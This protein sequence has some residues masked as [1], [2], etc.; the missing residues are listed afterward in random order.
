MYYLKNL[1]LH[2][3]QNSKMHNYIYLKLR[4]DPSAVIQITKILFNEVSVKNVTTLT[5]ATFSKVAHPHP[6]TISTISNLHIQQ[7]TYFTNNLLGLTL[8]IALL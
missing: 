8:L 3:F 2:P 1:T 5:E 4:F 7:S 6:S